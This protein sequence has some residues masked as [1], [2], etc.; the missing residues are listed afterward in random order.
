MK[1]TRR[2]LRRMIISEVKSLNEGTSAA[3]IKKLY[4]YLTQQGFKYTAVGA[5][6]VLYEIGDQVIDKI[7]RGDMKGAADMFV[8]RYK[9][10]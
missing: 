1:I 8:E 10:M 2:Q 7:T 4:D 5:S 9:K 3:S 6:M